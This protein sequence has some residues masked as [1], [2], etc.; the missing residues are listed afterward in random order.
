MSTEETPLTHIGTYKVVDKI[1]T[2]GMGEIYLVYDSCSDRNVALKK[3]R[4]D[5]LKYPTLKE[6]FLREAKIAAKMAHP[7]IIPIYSIHSDGEEIYYTMPYVEGETLKQIIRTCL[8]EEKAGKIIHPIGQSIPALMRIFLNICQAIAYCHSRGVLHRD[9]KPENVI[10]GKFGETFILDWGLADFVDS[11]MQDPK[12]EFPTVECVDLTRP[13]KIPGTLAYIPPE[14]ILGK[15]SSFATDI[16]ALGVIL[17]QLLTLRLPFHRTSNKKL[18]KQIEKEEFIDPL[19]RAPYRDIPLE[20]AHIA[21]ICLS[22]NPEARYRRVEDLLLEIE[23]YIA[24]RGQWTFLEPLDVANK[25][26][27][28]FQENI[29]VAKHT[30][31]TRSADL[32]EWVTI[33]LSKKGFS[34]NFKIETS[35]QLGPQSQGIGFLLNVPESNERKGL[36]EDSHSLWIGTKNTPGCTLFR[37]NVQILSAPDS[38][39]EENVCHKIRIE[40]VDSHMRVILDEKLILDYLTHIPFTGPHFGLLL[41]DADLQID[42]IK[43]YVTSPNIMINCL[44][45]PDTFLSTKNFSKALGEYRKISASFPGRTEGREA[46]FRAGI[47]LV[48]EA[49]ESKSSSKKNQLLQQALEEFGRLRNTPGA[50]LEYL[51]KSLVYKA[52]GEIEEESKCLELCLR[53]YTKHPLRYLIEEELIFRL[54]EAATQNRE[55]AYHFALLALRHMPHIFVE[56]QN[57]AL[58]DSLQSNWGPLPF[59]EPLSSSTIDE[60]YIQLSIHIAFWLAKPITLVEIIE[61]ATNPVLLSNALFCLLQLGCMSF[62]EENLHFLKEDSERLFSLSLLINLYKKQTTLPNALESLEQ[63]LDF[64]SKRALMHIFEK[65]LLPGKNKIEVELLKKLSSRDQDFTEYYLRSLIL[66]GQYPEASRCLECTKD[67][68][69]EEKNYFTGCLMAHDEGKESALNYL[70]EHSPSFEFSSYF[71]MENGVFSLKNTED[72]FFWEKLQ[73][74]RQM[75]LFGDCAKMKKETKSWLKLYQGQLSHVTATYCPT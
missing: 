36:L 18:K 39:L 21:K 41:K 6:R 25:L 55:A 61:S 1:A 10:V 8:E 47:T 75:I 27:W 11:P 13:G 12:E 67:L 71:V 15:P 14:R 16:Y 49:S 43:V 68:S 40:R 2:G 74:L 45:V 63:R 22:P 7:S 70:M 59:I 19:D 54:H 23:S 57:K 42:P 69:E 58:L 53:K 62:A 52:S 65:K 72:L 56:G 5:R 4:G 30:A 29:L 50:P 44:K 31:L 35:V 37:S 32:L 17:Y 9:V 38:Y 64:S 33:M 73:L 51:G 48:E 20:L 28:E 3:I 66:A 34:G 24:G 26:D 46:L 60:Q